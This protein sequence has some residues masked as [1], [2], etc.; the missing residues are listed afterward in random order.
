MHLLILGENRKFIFQLLAEL[1][2]NSE[3]NESLTQPRDRSLSLIYVKLDLSR[4]VL[5]DEV[6]GTYQF[7]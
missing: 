2:A 4:R 1:E 5:L 3:E 6:N 7:M